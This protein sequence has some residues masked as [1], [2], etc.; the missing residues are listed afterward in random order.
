MK[1]SILSP[2]TPRTWVPPFWV[3]GGGG[4]GGQKLN[5]SKPGL[6]NGIWVQ[7]DQRWTAVPGFDSTHRCATDRHYDR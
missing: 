2:L 6:Q 4:T 1:F 3:L 5:D 7:T